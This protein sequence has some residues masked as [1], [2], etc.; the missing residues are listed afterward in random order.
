[1]TE[2]RCR[3]CNRFIGYLGWSKHVLKHKKDFCKVIGR[4]VGEAHN[5]NWEDVVKYYNP[6]EAKES[7]CLNYELP[8]TKDLW[9]Y[10]K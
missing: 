6:K 3:V 5:I 2:I 4:F 8:K 9:S 10:Q 7:K 1:M